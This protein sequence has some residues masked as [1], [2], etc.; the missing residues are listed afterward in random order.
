MF[1]IVNGDWLIV[2]VKSRDSEC[3]R[4]FSVIPEG[5][6]AIHTRRIDKPNALFWG[7][8]Y[9]DFKKAIAYWQESD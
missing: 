8:Y 5:Q 6:F 3:E 4:T 7:H 1:Q 2:D 9:R